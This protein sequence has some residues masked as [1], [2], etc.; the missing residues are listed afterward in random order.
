[1]MLLSNLQIIIRSLRPTIH[2]VLLL[3]S[4]FRTQLSTVARQRR[5]YHRLK[6]PNLLLTTMLLMVLALALHPLGWTALAVLLLHPP[7]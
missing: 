2:L 4:I 1:M 6:S 3:M 5:M 7:A